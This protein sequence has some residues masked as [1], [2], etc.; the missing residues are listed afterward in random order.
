MELPLDLSASWHNRQRWLKIKGAPLGSSY[1][2]HILG[3]RRTEYS[4]VTKLQMMP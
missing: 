2:L 3:R 4:S 1:T